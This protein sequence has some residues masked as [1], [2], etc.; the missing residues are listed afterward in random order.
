M[1]AKSTRRN[2]QPMF[3]FLRNRVSRERK[4]CRWRYYDSKGSQLKEFKPSVWW[5]GVKKLSGMSSTV[6][7]SEELMRSLQQISEES[8]SALDLA[9]L[10]SDTFLSP[11]Q[12]FTQLSAESFQ[13]SQDHSTEQPFVVS[14]HAVYLQLVSINP[15]KASGPDGIPA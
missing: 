11:V 14:T 6:R 8:L 12:D 10:I 1:A 15:R 13:L 7:D 3:R 4:I 5:S 2:N 9:N